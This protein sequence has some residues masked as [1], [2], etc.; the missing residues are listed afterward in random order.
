MTRFLTVLYRPSA[1][2]HE[3]KA[4]PA[5]FSAFLL[6]AAISVAIFLMQYPGLIR[7]TID[8]LPSVATEGDRARAEEWL[9][10]DIYRRAAFL[11]VRLLAGWSAFALLLLSGVRAFG[12]T[13]GIRYTHLLSLE[14]HAE[15]VIVIGSA[16]AAAGAPGAGWLFGPGYGD[17]SLLASVNLCTLWYVSLLTR[18]ISVLCDTSPRK[19]FLIVVLSWGIGQALNFGVLSLLQHTF[20][21]G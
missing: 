18:G 1:R 12:L 16:L 17:F 5:W 4:Q 8:H 3:L 15:S 2:F 7:S 9:Q 13:R 20:R 21:L 6:L 11:P 14:I 19:A 10:T